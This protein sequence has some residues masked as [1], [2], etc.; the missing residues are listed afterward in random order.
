MPKY[1]LI[2]VSKK[3]LTIF[4]N[5][6]YNKRRLITR[7]NAKNNKLN[8]LP[9][10]FADLHALKY[11]NCSHNKFK[12]IPE[13]LINS[14][15]IEEIHF[16]YNLLNELNNINKFQTLHLLNVEGNFIENLPENI[17]DLINLTTINLTD[18]EFEEFPEELLQLKKI[19]KLIIRKNRIPSI[20]SEIK[21][22][23]QITHLDLS[24]NQLKSLPNEIV[25]LKNLKEI[26]LEKNL[27][28]LPSDYDPKKPFKI[29]DYVLK[30]QEFAK[31]KTIKAYVFKNLSRVC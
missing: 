25:E 21:K 1:N 2:N 12:T 7:I 13:V 30:Q 11:I 14:Q 20:P 9:S 4:P 24:N 5:I 10:F 29:I 16:D 3:E 28:E 26:H 15:K 6:I 8:D 22:L 23:N 17:E 19:K 27:I 18:N 31:L